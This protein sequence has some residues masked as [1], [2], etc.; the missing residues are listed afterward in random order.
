M[1]K[2]LFLMKL[3]NFNFLIIN[4]QWHFQKI[5]TDRLYTEPDYS[6]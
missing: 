2:H 1:N 6:F 5:L 4:K 3:I